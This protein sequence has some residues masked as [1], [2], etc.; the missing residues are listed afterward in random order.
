MDLYFPEIV[1]LD[2]ELLVAENSVMIRDLWFEP[3]SEI[4]EL[5]GELLVAENSVTIRDLW[6]EPESRCKTPSC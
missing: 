2:G 6:F 1:E 4:V 5:D 3:E